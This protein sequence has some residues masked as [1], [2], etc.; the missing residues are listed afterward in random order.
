M[1]IAVF[2]DTHGNTEKM[3]NIVRTVN[4]DIIMHL[5]DHDKDTKMLK[6][7]FSN[8]P[9]YSVCGNCDYGSQE[10]SEGILTFGKVNVF[11]THGHL[12]NVRDELDSLVYTA[13]KKN[14]QIALY[15]HTHIPDC[16]VIDGITVVNPGTAGMGWELTWALITLLDDGSFTVNICHI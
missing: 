9:V 5:G 6:Q 4:P 2:S 16:Q 13:K 11:A 10:P 15:G 12:Y 8:I 7:E 1:K 3:R 14:C